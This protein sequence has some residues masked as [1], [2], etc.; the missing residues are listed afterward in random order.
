MPHTRD[1]ARRLMRELEP[2]LPGGVEIVIE[3]RYREA[4]RLTEQAESLFK[5]ERPEVGLGRMLATRGAVLVHADR[6]PEAVSTIGSVL[7]GF[8][9]VRGAAFR[10]ARSIGSKVASPVNPTKIS[11]WFAAH[12]RKMVFR[13]AINASL[14][15]TCLLL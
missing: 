10:R 15:M 7:G 2:I 11:M 6:F 9:P 3:K 12:V 1:H 5:A 4:L 14:K 13:C 8:K